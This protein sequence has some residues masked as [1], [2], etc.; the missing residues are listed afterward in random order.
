MPI[1]DNRIG[2]KN[3]KSD[4]RVLVLYLLNSSTLK[5]GETTVG[6]T[7]NFIIGNF[8]VLFE[9]EQ[10]ISIMLMR[11]YSIIIVFMSVAWIKTTL[12]FV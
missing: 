8:F 7:G 4:F 1:I 11:Y 5:K 10:K 12:T 6:R 3:S 2:S 9:M